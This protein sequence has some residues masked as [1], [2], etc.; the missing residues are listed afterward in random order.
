MKRAAAIASLSSKGI[1]PRGLTRAE[2]AAYVG[3]CSRTFTKRVDGGELPGPSAATGRWDRVA[4]DQ[5]I[6]GSSDHTEPKSVRD[7]IEAAIANA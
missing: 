4:L 2:A 6:S 7:Q 5:A 1:V 3:L